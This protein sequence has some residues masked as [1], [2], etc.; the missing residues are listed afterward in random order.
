MNTMKKIL[1]TSATAILLLFSTLS[2]SK[3]LDKEPPAMYE[4][5]VLLTTEGMR[6][7]LNGAYSIM[8]G[9]GY[10]GQLLYLY[11]AAKGPDFFVRPT[12]AGANLRDEARYTHTERTN[13]NAR[14][15]WETIYRAIRNLTVI[16]ENIDEVQGETEE[17]R[18]ILGEAYFLR[19]LCYFDLM[20]LFAYPPIFS[21]P[22]HERYHEQFRWGVPVITTVSK[23]SDLLERTVRRETADSTYRFIIENFEL[24]YQFLE[25]RPL[26][27]GRVNSA[28]VKAL[29]IRTY[30]YLENWLRVVNL[31]EEWI[32]KY[33]SRY[34][35]IPYESWQTT[36]YTPFNSESI[37]EFNYTATENLGGS[38]LNF[39]VRRPTW[40]EPGSER[41][42]KVSRNEG[43]NKLGLT[44]G[45]TTRGR[46]FLEFYPNDVRRYL[47]CEMGIEGLPDYMTVRKYVGNPTHSVHNI[48]VV[49]LP[50]IY[51]SMAEAYANMGAVAQAAHYLSMVSQPR[52]RATVSVASATDV[53]NERRRE[54][55][56]EGH[57][58]WDH[59]R[60][61]RNITSRQ[62][63][64]SINHTSINFG[65]ITSRHYRVVYAIPLSELDA[66]VAIRDQQNPGYG[67]WNPA[68]GQDDD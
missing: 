5:D 30:L 29:L 63:I 48:P 35:M 52:R 21:I 40:N 46:D 60:T 20:R 18:R 43:H 12:E 55:I 42:G 16:I 17:L 32:T 9:S 45:A 27:P 39:W 47:I 44:W 23:G 59:F 62:V 14:S 1:I 11:E 56:L 25:G 64:E 34:A 50:E 7:L 66:N 6:A 2:C 31:G 61:A 3:I 19:G 41:D 4:M 15:L 51:L 10:Y 67:P 49:R 8:S 57:T 13:R 37:W 53:L 26:V 54:L 68:I 65:T 58:Y 38:S 33:G 24:A 36:Y 22:G 28:T